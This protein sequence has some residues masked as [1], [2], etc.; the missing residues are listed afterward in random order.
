M[1][2][3]TLFVDR[4]YLSPYALTA[5]VA[6][7]EKGLEY[8]LREVALDRGEQRAP[9]FPAFTG[10]VPVL[11]HGEYVLSESIAI[12]EYLAET[13]PYPS[14]APRM[15]FPP[16]FRERGICREV[17][18]WVRT[19]LAPIREE[20]ATHTVFYARAEAPLSDAAERAVA[21][22]LRACDRLIRPGMTTLFDAWCIAD[23]DLAMMLQRLNA[24]GHLLPEHVKAYVEA[25]W[26]RPSVRK[27]WD[28]PRP[29]F[30]P[31]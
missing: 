24:N 17:M 28:Q 14:K 11:R 9:D 16:D 22:L 12:A 30:V 18:G 7:E 25:N 13:F 23:V 10:R 20:R 8:E 26:A 5:F 6:L 27:W 21:K 2:A 4:F 1:E 3:L 19:D 29:P 15:L 31:Y